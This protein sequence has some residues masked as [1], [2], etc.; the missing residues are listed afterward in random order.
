MNILI[1]RT[2]IDCL[3]SDGTI[4]PVGSTIVNYNGIYSWRSI[5]EKDS[6]HSLLDIEKIDMENRKYFERI[7]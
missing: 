7:Y 5:N 1:Y 6:F 4:I 3:M 2:L